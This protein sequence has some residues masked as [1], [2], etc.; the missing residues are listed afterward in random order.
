MTD[1]DLLAVF[2]AGA[3]PE[4]GLRH[5]DHVRLAW[6]YLQRY[7]LPSVLERMSAGLRRLA[8][9]AGRDGLYHETITWAHVFLVRERMA[10]EDPGLS[11]DAFAACVGDGNP[12]VATATCTTVASGTCN[13]AWQTLDAASSWYG[14]P[15]C[16]CVDQRCQSSTT[17]DLGSIQRVRSVRTWPMQCEEL[18]V[19]TSTDGTSFTQQ[20]YGADADV[21]DQAW[22]L[23]AAIGG[24]ILAFPEVDARWVRVT[25]AN[26]WCAF[27]GVDGTE[28]NACP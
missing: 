17:A 13:G 25:V 14:F 28:V 11:W 15:G 21:G 20:Y 12:P 9:A 22:G 4:G 7:P 1:L 24:D 19:E 26:N 5:R 2:E 8:A 23:D 3:A 6:L 18:W 10:K 27:A 16:T